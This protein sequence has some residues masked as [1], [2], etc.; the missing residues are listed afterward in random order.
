[1]ASEKLKLEAIETDDEKRARYAAKLNQHEETV[2]IIRSAFVIDEFVTDAEDVLE[3]EVPTASYL[4][5]K[6]KVEAL[7]NAKPFSDED[8]ENALKELKPQ[9]TIIKYKRLTNADIVKLNKYRDVN[10]RGLRVI[11]LLLS[12]ADPS[13]TYE[14]ICIMDPIETSRILAAITEK[15]PIFL[16]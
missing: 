1:M 4:L 7:L 13:V 6:Q 8:F 16:Q 11:F 5:E 10:E 3:V 14:K 15:S 9:F 2:E 12:R